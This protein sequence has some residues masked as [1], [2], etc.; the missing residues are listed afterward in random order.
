L[1]QKSFNILSYQKCTLYRF[2]S[3]C[4]IS[5]V[6]ICASAKESSKKRIIV[7]CAGLPYPEVTYCQRL[8]CDTSLM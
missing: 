5:A 6:G 3:C 8:V 7:H 2:I 4:I 1:E